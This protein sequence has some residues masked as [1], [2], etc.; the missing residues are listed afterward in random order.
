MHFNGINFDTFRPY[1]VVET[2]HPPETLGVVN[3]WTTPMGA[4]AKYKG[5]VLA[6]YTRRAEIRVIG[7][8]LREASDRRQELLGLLL[9]DEVSSLQFRNEKTYE[10]A[11]IESIESEGYTL[12]TLKM[13]LTFYCPYGCS[14]GELMV[15]TLSPET[16]IFSTG[17]LPAPPKFTLK[18]TS[19]TI[20]IT[21]GDYTWSISGL[22]IGQ[23]IVA[24]FESL[25]VFHGLNNIRSKVSIN[26]DYFDI[27]PNEQTLYLT[28]ATGTVTW[29][30]RW[31]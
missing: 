24:D 30:P 8:T 16:V 12:N 18:A 28:G 10:M 6:P 2:V 21:N 9:R 22:T 4:G 7:G 5:M 26:S 13:T 19:T 3:K 25:S 29:T 14:F 27:Q 1:F 20:S 31:Q 23:D 11:K 17:V 15:E